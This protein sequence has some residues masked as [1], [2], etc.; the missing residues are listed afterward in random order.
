MKVIV[1]GQKEK[2]GETKNR[3]GEGGKRKQRKRG[4]K[5]CD[6]R[7][8]S[9]RRR[10]WTIIFLI[11]ILI[12][13]ITICPRKLPSTHLNRTLRTA[14]LTP[15]ILLILIFPINVLPSSGM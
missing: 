3:W 8:E 7:F 1:I 13:E 15:L 4:K 6:C 5:K 14:P 11:L 10:W 2:G 9:R 12:L